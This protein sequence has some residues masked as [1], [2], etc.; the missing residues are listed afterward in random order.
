[1][2]RAAVC[3]H[4]CNSSNLAAVIKEG[5]L[6]HIIAAPF[7]L[8]EEVVISAGL[9]VDAGVKVLRESKG[10][11]AEADSDIELDMVAG[12]VEAA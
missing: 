2:I 7:E 6:H 8:I 10:I 9:L 12:I 3:H 1:M 11:H 4:A 5:G